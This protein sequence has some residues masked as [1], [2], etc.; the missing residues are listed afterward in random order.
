MSGDG[1]R[2][3]LAVLDIDGV[4]ADVRHRLGHLDR[5]PGRRPDWDAFF[6][7]AEADPPLP[8]GLAVA[9]RLALDHDVVYV[10]GRPERLREVTEAWL[11]HHAL[12]DGALHLRPHGDRRPGSV[13]KRSVVRRLAVEARVAVA[14]DDDVR[15]VRALAG[16]GVE[17]LHA[18]WGDAADPEA[19][20]DLGRAQGAEGLT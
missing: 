1:A 18:D 17:V 8:E 13:L 15:V 6:A 16:I 2:R 12:P 7:A 9:A 5:S 14:V 10:S 3:P 4:L 20:A 11:A 19:S